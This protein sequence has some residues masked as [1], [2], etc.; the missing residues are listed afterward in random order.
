M[1]GDLRRLLF[2]SDAPHFGGAER[3]VSDLARAARRRGMAASVCWIRPAGSSPDVFAEAEEAGAGL[4]VI[5]PEESRSFPSLWRALDRVLLRRRPDG[6][7][8]NACGRSRFWISPWA[9][10]YHR[11]PSL[12]IHHMVDQ[13]DY[14]RLPPDRLGGRIEGLHLWRW[15]QAMRHRLAA[16][17]ATAIV[18]LN[19]EDRLQ[20][21]REHGLRPARVHVVRDG[22]DAERYRPAP[23]R[24]PAGGDPVV[25][26]AGRL[27]EGKGIEMLIEAAARL[28]RGGLPLTVRVAGDGPRRS[29]LETHA[30]RYG[31][32]DRV[33]FLG[34]VH[35]M[36]A[37][38]NSLDVFA[39]CSRTES[40]GLVLSEA[41]ACG[42][43]VV[44]TPTAG[45]R[46]QIEDG[47]SGC[48]LPAFSA[49]SLADTLRLLCADA[50]LR[51]RMGGCARRRVLGAF[52][53]DST[54]DRVL[55][56]LGRHRRPAEAPSMMAIAGTAE[57]A[58]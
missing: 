8:I 15:P 38:Y 22:V 24:E 46:C 18:V 54:L 33:R 14:R 44:A 26:T 5:A 55:Q 11:V 25:G 32:G 30:R 52:C 36:P 6:A 16:T 56:L 48:V 39:L 53:V 40:F 42:R 34:F 51:E 58:A 4:D 2:L 21:A 31:M 57:D 43:A 41:M 27:V 7:L 29:A 50:P 20:V 37:F 45:A 3:C 1:K 12:W 47:V 35:D 28:V 49:E 23:A 9:A 13:Q 10:R 17:G 19:D